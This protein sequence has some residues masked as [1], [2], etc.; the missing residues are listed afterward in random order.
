MRHKLPGTDHH[1]VNPL[2]QLS[3]VEASSCYRGASQQ[4]KHRDLSGFT[5]QYHRDN[6]GVPSAAASQVKSR[7]YTQS[8]SAPS[9]GSILKVYV[10][11][12]N[13]PAVK[14][15]V[16]LKVKLGQ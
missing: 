15:S 8:L 1:S 9:T 13:S 3:T 11:I 6:T 10:A 5:F 2:M 7:R 16:K 12:V 4:H 14:L